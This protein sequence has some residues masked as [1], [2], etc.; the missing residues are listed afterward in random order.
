[1]L[2]AVVV[3]LFEFGRGRGLF[4]VAIAAVALSGGEAGASGAVDMEKCRRT[5]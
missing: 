4:V 3:A 1:M 2:V 5:C